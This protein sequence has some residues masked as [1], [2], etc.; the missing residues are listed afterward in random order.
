[1]PFTSFYYRFTGV[2]DPTDPSTTTKVPV[3]P[4]TTTKRPVCKNY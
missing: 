1:M 4:S 2:V 3:D